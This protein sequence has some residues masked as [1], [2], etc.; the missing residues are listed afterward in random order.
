MK[1]RKTVVLSLTMAAALIFT[2]CAK[3]ESGGTGSAASGESASQE[4][5]RK[6][7]GG[8]LSFVS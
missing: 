8:F 4:A 6:S 3:T 7:L 2:G 1:L 5:T